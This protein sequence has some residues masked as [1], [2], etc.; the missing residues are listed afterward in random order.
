MAN[1]LPRLQQEGVLLAVVA[2]KDGGGPDDVPAAG[3]I[4]GDDIAQPQLHHD[5]AAGD[6]DSGGL[7]P[8]E[9]EGILKP[10]RVRVTGGKAQHIDVVVALAVDFDDLFFRLPLDPG[11]LLQVQGV[12]PFIQHR[13][14]GD[15]G[16]GQ[17]G[18]VQVL[19]TLGNELF[20]LSQVGAQGIVM[21]HQGAV[22]GD[23]FPHPGQ[24]LFFQRLLQ[25]HHLAVHRHADLIFK[26]YQ[27]RLIAHIV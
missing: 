16:L 27:K 17:A 3:L 13:N 20:Q 18:D 12:L 23:Q 5:A 26:F 1:P 6:A 11:D 21:D 7:P 19:G 24:A 22:G 4:E 9:G 10:R 14:L 2:G 15:N 8:L 25:G